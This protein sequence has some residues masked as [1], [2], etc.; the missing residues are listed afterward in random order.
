MNF[1]QSN[2]SSPWTFEALQSMPKVELHRHLEC[3]LRLSTL[4][5]LAK[6]LGV[7]IPPTVS[8]IKSEFLVTEPMRDLASVLKKFTRTQ[9]VLSSEEILSRI[10]F[11]AIQDAHAEGIKILELR[12]APTFI[13]EGHDN[14]NFEKIIRSVRAGATHASHLPMATGFI[15]I[16]QRNL[17]VSVAERVVDFALEHKDFFVALDLADNEDGFE[18]Q[19]FQKCFEKARK[20]GLHITVHAGEASIPQASLNVRNA[21]ELLGAERI[22][23]GVQI[24]CD[25]AVIQLVRE[26]GIPLELCLTSN[27]L[28]QAVPSL[29]AHPIR[30]LMEAGVPV[31]VNTDDPGIFDTSLTREYEILAQS[32]GFTASEFEK[33]NE[34]AAQAS[35]IPLLEKQK[36][37]PRPIHSLR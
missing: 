32:H 16:I 28:T 5:E 27:W 29:S 2:S 37:W 4:I 12:W 25:P 17:P 10:T 1:G 26:K 20:G 24:H 7:E 36:Y 13:Q 14:L 15:C 3:S 21:I 31:T 35:F 34:T 30:S 22:G 33:C 11:E 23:H 6:D 19:L 8:E 9:A 18:P